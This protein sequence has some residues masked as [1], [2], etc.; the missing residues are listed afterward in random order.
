LPLRLTLQE[1]FL[2]ITMNYLSRPTPV[3][4]PT[5]MMDVITFGSNVAD[6]LQQ[7]YDANKALVDQTLAQYE[8]LK[9]L[10]PEDDAYI[11][12]QVSNIKTQ[13]DSLGGLNLAH[14]TGRDTVLNNLKTVLKDPIVQNI[15]TSKHNKDALDAEFQKVKEKDHTKANMANYEFALY[16]GGYQD[17]IQGKSKKVSSM[18][19]KPYD[20][21]QGNVAKRLKEY[22]DQYDDE[23]YLGSQETQFQTVDL[24]G[25][26]I[27]KQDLEN[28]IITTTTPSEQEQLNI[29]AWYKYKDT[30]QEDIGKI[31]DPV[32]KREA[33][34]IKLEMSALKAK[35][36]TGDKTAKEMLRI[37][38]EQFDA[39][40]SKKDFTKAD[41]YQYETG[42][43]V[44][45][46]ASLYDKNIITKRDKDNLKFEVYKFG[47][48]TNIELEKLAVAKEANRLKQAENKIAQQVA[49]GDVVTK[50]TPDE[51]DK[52]TDV[53]NVQRRTAQAAT[54]LDQYLSQNVEGYDDMNANEK[55]QY[56]L[57]YNPSDPT[58]KGNKSTGAVL[59]NEFKSA[60]RAY[61]ELANET[62]VRVSQA[63][64]NSYN[65]MIGGSANLENL[66]ST[67][68]LTAKLLQKNKGVSFE[69]LH[70]SE[71]MGLI[72]EWTANKLQYDAPSDKDVKSMYSSVVIKNKAALS[73]I[74]S[75]SARDVLE[76]IKSTADNEEEAFWTPAIKQ[77]G[78][79]VK[80][81]IL[82]RFYNMAGNIK[83]TF[84]YG[85]D[86]A[87]Q[88][89]RTADA[90]DS[91]EHER[92]Y[93][94]EQKKLDRGWRNFMFTEDTNLTELE[95]RDLRIKG[96]KVSNDIQTVFTTLD[97][98]V[99]KAIQKTASEYQANIKEFSAFNFS[100]EVK[101]QKGT[102]QKLRAVVIDALGEGKK[103]PLSSNDYTLSRE[104]DSYR[105][106]YTDGDKLRKSVLVGKLDPSIIQNIDDKKADWLKD[107]KNTKIDLMPMTFEPIVSPRASQEK[108]EAFVENIADAGL[109]P[110]E[111]LENMRSNPASTPLASVT[112]L[113]QKVKQKYG[114]DFYNKN[115]AKV[116]EILNSKYTAIPYSTGNA[117]KVRI[118][119]KEDGRDFAYHSQE[120]V[121]QKD[122]TVLFIMQLN[123][124]DA[125]KTKRIEELR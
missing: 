63:V 14:N 60:Q 122:D 5:N 71:K 103:A 18:S 44:S 95:P 21:V 118:D 73:K 50:E 13:I 20:D 9:G 41:L 19:Y 3:V 112:D 26:R 10:T 58:I 79:F 65:S 29:N 81:R 33:S 55:W 49:G 59:A 82:D 115:K 100:T 64:K 108:V 17:Y 61:Y 43:F 1:A 69:S 52:S 45:N 15:L 86:Y 88:A 2:I 35:A 38:T 36:D 125:L 46:M 85:S 54:A 121:P 107:P 117:F 83:N 30:K 34:S 119:Y 47:V 48:N 97:T 16:Q 67:M 96:G 101:D 114:A 25:K 39:L 109:Y 8:S 76:T 104:G 84:V 7:R 105:I 62:E 113:V 120:S 124:L 32:Y 75:D 72:A 92:L 56:K 110:P 70:N 99:Q 123:A 37:K 111:V 11:A 102:A 22:V 28:F 89:K 98:D 4:Q 57:N 93:D 23:Q 87:D 94:K 90:E 116:E 31:L 51:Q 68:P 42:K 24:F 78:S 53:E 80:N 12:S 74:K 106:H 40:N 6:N 66:K 77:A 91:A 27:L